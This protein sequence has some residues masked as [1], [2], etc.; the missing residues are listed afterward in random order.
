MIRTIFIEGAQYYH[1][2]T[3]PTVL[4]VD[5]LTIKE[6]NK[7][8]F[9]TTITY[10]IAGYEGTCRHNLLKIYEHENIQTVV[11]MHRNFTE[12]ADVQHIF[13]NQTRWSADDPTITGIKDLPIT[14]AETTY[15]K[16]QQE[17]K[18]KEKKNGL[19]HA[20]LLGAGFDLLRMKMSRE[21]SAAYHKMMSDLYINKA[22]GNITQREFYISL[23]RLGDPH[24][25]ERDIDSSWTYNS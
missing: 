25:I 6:I 15:L 8:F 20:E 11:G 22:N 23:A 2:Q 10:K 3:T 5:M 7:G 12:V 21:H 1:H 16:E 9:K 17:R 18:E 19:V 24:Y 4:R 14:P 13:H